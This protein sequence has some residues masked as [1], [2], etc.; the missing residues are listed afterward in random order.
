MPDNDKK[1][2]EELV[3]RLCKQ[4]NLLE[5]ELNKIIAFCFPYWGMR[6]F[7]VKEGLYRY[8]V[9][10]ARILDI[11]NRRFERLLRRAVNNTRHKLLDIDRLWDLNRTNTDEPFPNSR[12]AASLHIVKALAEDS[13]KTLDYLDGE[14]TE[15]EQGATDNL[16]YSIYEDDKEGG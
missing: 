3:K 4:F 7:Y 16:L 12:E 1:L 15:I 6:R 2:C 10:W 5:E 14:D 8:K 11:P 9:K 13:G